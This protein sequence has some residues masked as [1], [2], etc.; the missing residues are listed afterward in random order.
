MHNMSKTIA[1]YIIIHVTLTSDLF[2]FFST[3]DVAVFQHEQATGSRPGDAGRRGCGPTD[4][5]PVW[6]Q[7]SVHRGNIRS[8]GRLSRQRLRGIS[9]RLGFI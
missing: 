9:G 6:Q 2:F 1:Y 7:D 4:V 3:N 8:V 5:A